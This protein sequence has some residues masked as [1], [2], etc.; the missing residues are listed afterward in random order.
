MLVLQFIPNPR[1]AV[2]EMRRVVRPGGLVTAAVWDSY[3]GLPHTRLVW[4]IAL[5]IDDA[6][7]APMLRPLTVPNGMATLWRDVGLLDV[8]QTSLSIRMDFANFEDYWLPLSS[9][10]PVAQYVDGLSTSLRD[11]LTRHV[12]RAYLANAPDGPRSFASTAWACRGT[13]P[14]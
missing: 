1:R 2:V 11:S 8:E 13:V 14:D 6:F 12:R 9:E 10:G 7:E 3:G 4:D 5:T